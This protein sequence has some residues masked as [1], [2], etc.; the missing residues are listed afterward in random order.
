MLTESQTQSAKEIAEKQYVLISEITDFDKGYN[1]RIESARLAF[2]SGYTAAIEQWDMYSENDIRTAIYLGR[3]IMVRISDM[4]EDGFAYKTKEE[5]INIIKQSKELKPDESTTPD[6]AAV[7]GEYSKEDMKAFESIMSELGEV[8]NMLARTHLNSEI[9]NPIS[10]KFANA[11]VE[12]FNLYNKLQ[13]THPA[14]EGK[15]KCIDFALWIRNNGWS[16]I[17]YK[18]QELWCDESQYEWMGEIDRLITSDELYDKFLT[19]LT[20]K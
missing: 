12:L 3:M 19:T 1:N 7:E 18:E 9:Y 8:H 14:L 11:K 4:K 13:S 16:V 5:I 6:A 20:N 10:T 2:L 17:K 15:E